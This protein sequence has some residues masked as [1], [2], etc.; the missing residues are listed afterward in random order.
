MGGGGRGN[1]Y[2][3]GSV[4]RKGGVKDAECCAMGT[5]FLLFFLSSV[6]QIVWKAFDTRGREDTDLSL[7]FFSLVR[8]Q[9]W[10]LY[11]RHS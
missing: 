2:F 5:F 4:Q 9:G 7:V 1:F 11:A 6:V 3:F 10:S 8:R